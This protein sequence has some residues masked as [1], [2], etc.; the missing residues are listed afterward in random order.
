MTVYLMIGSSADRARGPV[1]QSV[2]PMS[3]VP[4][5]GIEPT[6]LL[7]RSRGL[8]PL[9]LPFRHP[10][11]LSAMISAHGHETRGSEITMAANQKRNEDV[12]R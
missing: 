2:A 10:G 4:G 8:S 6:H 11:N 1:G 3:V 7:G 9:R 5:V 12:C